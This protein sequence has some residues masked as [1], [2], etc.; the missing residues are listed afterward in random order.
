M[1]SSSSSAPTQPPVK[2]Y[3][4]GGDFPER[5]IPSPPENAS[6][7]AKKTIE[8]LKISLYSKNCERAIDVEFLPIKVPERLPEIKMENYTQYV[9][10]TFPIYK[11]E[12]KYCL[13]LTP[14]QN[15]DKVRTFRSGLNFDLKLG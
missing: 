8:M 6:E 14:I 5:K 10:K 4:T 7:A 2:L 1:A 15:L 3:V 9:L 11:M 13:V 12:K